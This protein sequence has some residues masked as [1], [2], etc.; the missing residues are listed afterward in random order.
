M[1]IVY[2]QSRLGNQLF[3]YAFFL[4]LKKKGNRH[5]YLDTT[6]PYIKKY[7]GFEVKTIFTDIQKDSILPYWIAR[8]FYLLGDVLKKVFKLNLQT[9]VENPHGK[10][11]WWKGYWQ[12]YKYPE[13]VRE[14]LNK[15]L[16]FI[17]VDDEKNKAAQEL[18]GASNAVSIHIRRGD[19]A[20]PAIRPT[21][22]DIC[23]VHYY[24]EAMAYI[25]Q[26]TENPRFFVFSDDPHWVKENLQIADAV[27][28][29]WNHK[30]NSFRDMQL[31]SACR[32]NIIANSSFSWWGAWL[33]K[34]P[35]KIVVCPS[36][37]FHNYPA[38][39]IEKLLP[40]SWHRIG[41]AVPNVS[42]II[43]D[44][45]EQDLLPVLRQQYADFELLTDAEWSGICDKRIKPATQEPAG[46][47]V[48]SISKDE[49][50]LFKNKKY[51]HDK[52]V[53]YFTTWNNT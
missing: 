46:N 7:G 51:L 50:P 42:L 49:L 17:P 14:E 10:K 39:F 30:K 9:D 2:I 37:W 45:R 24:Q 1:K 6:A 32:H 20:Q 18:I 8:P 47:H 12:E 13:Y 19:Y 38:D 16:Q 26:K 3:Q 23:N 40:P 5:V 36:K 4:Y 22:G 34:N 29:D 15:E 53:N 27:Y 25:R 11:V 35:E 21:F 52:L 28:V 31:M 48:F 44:V 43:N 41:K 33:N